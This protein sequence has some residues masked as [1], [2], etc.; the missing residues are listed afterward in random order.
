[1]II[2]SN[3]LKEGDSIMSEK[4]EFKAPTT[5]KMNSWGKN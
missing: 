1:M 5:A 2:L 4:E 3:N